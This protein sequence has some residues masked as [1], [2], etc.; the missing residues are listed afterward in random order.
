MA[1]FS[2]TAISIKVLQAAAKGED[3]DFY[4]DMAS[5]AAPSDLFKLDA[6][7]NTT[8]GELKKTIAKEK[9][10]D[11]QKQKFMLFGVELKDSRTLESCGFSYSDDPLLHMIPVL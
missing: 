10:F 8:I 2:N 11:V 1:A 6:N 7:S 3:G 5:K 4:W 9:G